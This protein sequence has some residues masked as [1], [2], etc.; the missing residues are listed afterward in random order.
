MNATLAQLHAFEPAAIG[1]ANSGRSA[2]YF[3]R[4]LDTWSK[5]YHAN[6]D[7]GR[8]A[9]MDRVIEWLERNMP[10]EDDQV[11]VVH[12]DFRI[13]NMIF[14]PTEPRVIA[15]LDWELST[16]GH[17]TGREAIP[18]YGD[19]L[20]FNYFR[21]AAIFHGIK[22]RVIRGTAASANA[23]ERARLSSTLSDRLVVGAEIRGVDA[24]GVPVAG[25]GAFPP[26]SGNVDPKAADLR[27]LLD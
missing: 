6:V 19:Y 2:N 5:Q 26:R 15:V 17:R 3:A 4:Q 21:L 22:G 16:L 1:L 18:D 27:E 9:D 20:A 8:D 13:D 11:G 14:H 7:A 25:E 10:A 23:A 24:A 12:G